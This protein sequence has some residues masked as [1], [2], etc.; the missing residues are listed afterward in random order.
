MLALGCFHSQEACQH[1]LTGFLVLSD[2]HTFL[3][4]RAALV[5]FSEAEELAYFVRPAY[6]L[7][8]IVLN[9]RMT[10]G[11]PPSVMDDLAD[12]LGF[13]VDDPAFEVRTSTFP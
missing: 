11:T 7:D 2:G 10:P 6:N 13:V 9:V 1:L 8:R 4:N 5:G 12:D 3:C